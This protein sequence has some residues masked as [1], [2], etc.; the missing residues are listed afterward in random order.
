MKKT[1]F[2]LLLLILVGL[3]NSSQVSGTPISASSTITW[4]FNLGT[5]GQLATFST[6][7]ADY[8]NTNWVS[9][10]TNLAYKD[11]ATNYNISYTR[12]QPGTQSASVDGT[13]LISFNLRPITGLSFTPTS[14]S[15]DCM[16]Y[17]TNGGSIDVVWK[18]A[19]GTT[20]TI[21]TALIPARDNS[22]AGTHATYDLTSLSIPASSGDCALYVYIY[23][24]GNSKQV[25]LAN[26]VINGNVTG[27]VINVNKYTLALAA[28]PTTGGTVSCTPIGTTFDEGTP[29]TVNAARGF[30]YKFSHWTNDAQDTVSKNSSYTFN[31]TKNTSL[32]AVFK[33]INT[34]SLTLNT[35]GGGQNYM[36]VVSPAGTIVGGLNMYEGGTTVTLT[37]CNNKILTFTNWLTGETN[38]TITLSMT[39]DQTVTAVYSVVDYIVG[40]DFYKSGGSSRLADFYS[41]SDNQTATLILRKA[42]GTVNSWLDKSDVATAAAYNVGRGSG[43][44]WKPL[45]DH[46]YFQT[47]FNAKDFTDIK[48][49]AGMQYSYNTYSTQKCQYSLDGTNFTSVGTYTL[50]NSNTWVDSTFNLPADAN[51][52]AKVYVRWIS[53]TTSTIKG[54]VAVGNDGITISNIFLTA[55]AS[56]YNDGK[57]PALTSSIPTSSTV[58]ASATGKVVL[59]F[60]KKVMLAAGT[61]VVATLGDKQITP[62]VSGQTISFPY[63]GLEYTK[64]YT[65]TLPA[66]SVSDLSGNILASSITI[67]FTTMTR[68]AVAKKLFDFVVGVDGDFKAAITAATTASISGDRFR[69]F[70]PN[71][72]Y[73]IGT[74]TGDANQ[75][76]VIALPNISY[77]GESTNGV[78][79]Y[80][81]PTTE[82]ISI[83]AT[84]AFTNAANDIYMQDLNLLNKL[85]YH[86]GTFS[87]RAAALQDQGTR[88]IYKNVNLLSDQDTYYS[89]SGRSYFENGSIHG[90][91]DFLCGGGDIFFNEITLYLEERTGNNITAPATASNWG[92]VFN[93]CTIDGFAITN[94]N[95]TLGRPWQNSPRSA[96]INTK[97]KVLPSAAGWTEMSVVPA[98]FAEYNSTTPDGTPIDLSSRKSTYT[99]SNTYVNPVLTAN[100]AAQYTL[101]NVVGGN[102]TWQPKLYT[103][104]AETPVISINGTTISW[105]DNTYVLCWEICKDGKFVKFVASN[106]YEIPTDA[107]IGTV[108]TVRAANAMGGLSKESNPVQFNNT[109]TSTILLKATKL[110]ISQFDNYVV[111]SNLP[112][113]STVN[114]YGLT[115]ILLLIKENVSESVRIPV[116]QNL[117]LQVKMQSG[118][119]VFKILKR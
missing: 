95:F 93:N 45:A 92:Y 97:M 113:N 22:G 13:N 107:V 16:R 17:G 40:W 81:K 10:G 89:G 63:S 21:A 111:I 50:T 44:S 18:N 34:Y 38:P 31:I 37:A 86:S 88:N 80:N 59:T 6:G 32:Y 71:G 118:V 70:F 9:N 33:P 23:N 100:Q 14:I 109:S 110:K 75:K 73:N 90:T 119:E 68:P 48:V 114:V 91:V 115:G 41:T 42:D 78:N 7:T 19:D 1:I 11:V 36:V 104:Q 8:F 77:I 98:V 105:T 67:T 83:T 103:E 26:I 108:Y 30:G 117:I 12:F 60:D 28:S 47:N 27:E 46:N 5:A 112:Q 96:Y 84:M 64:Q 20:Q 2:L 54:T 29:I 53:D 55:T 15:F 102:D 25:G 94:G 116:N 43:I 99:A 106:S 79:L 49:S 51:H 66:N 87:G 35:T 4:P 61:T 72:D 76:T 65:F 56:I 82:G 58:N 3:V 57:A 39:Q 52:A 69:I 101:E 85:D 24:L 74:N 62:A